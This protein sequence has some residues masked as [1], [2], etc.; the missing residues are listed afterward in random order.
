LKIIEDIFSFVKGS[1]PLRFGFIPV[2]DKDPSTP[3]ESFFFERWLIGLKSVSQAP[4]FQG[5]STAL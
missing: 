4:Y 3:R 1:I 2:V 5:R